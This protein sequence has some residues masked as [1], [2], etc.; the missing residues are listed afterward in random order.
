[1]TGTVFPL[2]ERLHVD[3]YSLDEIEDC[4]YLED[5]RGIFENGISSESPCSTFEFRGPKPFDEQASKEFDTLTA[6]FRAAGVGVIGFG[7]DQ[8]GA[9]IQSGGFSIGCGDLLVYEP[10]YGPLE[11]TADL[12]NQKL[13]NRPLT[14]D[15]Y[16]EA[17][18]C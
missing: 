17:S 7:V 9:V 18:V 14:P 6:A 3:E 8:A 11:N 12:P 1:M 2:I 10:G 5:P 13:L 15:W 4:R 16:E